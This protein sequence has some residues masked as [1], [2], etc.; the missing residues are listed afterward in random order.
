MTTCMDPQRAPEAATRDQVARILASADFSRSERL[1]RFLSFIVEETLAGRGDRLKAY[2]IALSVFERPATFDPQ[3]DPLVRIEATRLRRALEHYYL[4]EGRADPVVISVPK[5]AYVPLFVPRADEGCELAPYPEP[6]PEVT[7]VPPAPERRRPGILAAIAASTVLVAAGI[8]AT[9]L[10]G[11]VGPERRALTAVAPAQA[12]ALAVLPFRSAGTD[13]LGQRV[14]DGLDEALIDQ[15]AKLGDVRVLGSATSQLVHQLQGPGKTSDSLGVR[16]FVEGSL[17]NQDARATVAVRLV[18]YDQRQVVW[19]T[20]IPLTMSGN[21]ATAQSEIATAMARILAQPYGT[22]YRIGSAPAGVGSAT[23]AR[24]QSCISGFYGYR[25]SLSADAHQAVRDC[26]EDT[27]QRSPGYATAWAMLSLVYLDEIRFGLNPTGT[28]PDVV[29]RAVAAADKAVHLEPDNIRALQAAM[30]ARFF[31]GDIAGGRAAGERALEI[32]PYD[33]EVLAEYGVR[34]AQVGEWS[35][36]ARMLEAALEQDPPNAGLLHGHAAFVLLMEGQTEKA[37]GHLRKMSL[38]PHPSVLLVQL[39]VHAETGDLRSARAALARLR[40]T[41]PDFVK[42]LDKQLG[43]RN[44]PASDLARIRSIV[45]RVQATKMAA[46]T[47]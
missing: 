19:S 31:A 32:N 14:V 9:V 6:G 23:A 46:R 22:L 7:A 43:V 10:T 34:L 13:D 47:H 27:V 35:R 26:L 41:A 45:Q 8:V 4:T 42:D 28:L 1:S 21:V 37:A 15:L 44:I 3:A 5:G 33:T 36:G 30:L 2:T 12:P 39:L 16:Y 17:T 29:K 24:G 18:D 11:T 40:E 20:R 38:E 25:K